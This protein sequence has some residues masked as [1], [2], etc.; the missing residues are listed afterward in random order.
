MW[1]LVLGLFAIGCGSETVAPQ[2]NI[3]P[4]LGQWY[5]H[6]PV[7]QVLSPTAFDT[8]TLHAA[9]IDIHPE[10]P[11]NLNPWGFHVDSTTH[12]R[13]MVEN[14]QIVWRTQD[15]GWRYSVGEVSVRHDTMTLQ[16]MW[17]FNT[18]PVIMVLRPNGTLRRIDWSTG[19]ETAEVWVRGWPHS[20]ARI[21]P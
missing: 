1:R 6:S 8:L 9:G 21:A 14:N 20:T 3:T 13:Q 15:R 2:P 10:S 18:D 7:P 16:M 12:K 5:L 4:F 17:G 19:R 11:V